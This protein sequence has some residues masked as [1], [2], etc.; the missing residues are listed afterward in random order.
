MTNRN[1]LKEAIA[2][3]KAVKETAIANAKA[4]LEEAFTPHL[5]SM[6]SK[7][8]EEMDRE[9]DDV[10]EAMKSKEKKDMMEEFEVNKF[11]E[12]IEEEFDLNEILAEL[13]GDEDMTEEVE[14]SEDEM[15]DEMDDAEVDLEDMSEADLKSFIEDVIADMVA[16]GELEA[17]EDFED[18]MGE[19]EMEMGDEEVEIT[20][21][22]ISEAIDPQTLEML[23]AALGPLVIGGGAF[24]LDK[25]MKALKSGKAGKVGQ[26]LANQLEKAGSAA[27][28]TLRRDGKSINES[29]ISEAIDPQTLEMLAAALGPLVIGGGAFALDKA[30]KA[31]KSGKA[32]KVGQALAN[33]LEKAG[34]A[35]GS[36]L[37]RDGKAINEMEE[38]NKLKKELQEVNLLNAKLL[39]TNKIFKSKNLSEDQKIKVLKSFDKAE[40]VKEA[41]IIFETLNEG[42]TTPSKSPMM[43]IKG[44]A[45]RPSGVIKESKQPVMEVDPQVARWQKIAGI[46]K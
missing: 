40:S 17:G 24:A 30:M 5:K 45:S 9:D 42:I 25:A 13:E 14:S 22:D 44:S 33:Q 10:E 8:L 15:E 21:S 27:G 34:S 39:Y 35:A 41:K 43:G 28:S 31:L 7:K 19:E 29:D 4:A 23:A 20:E 12:N 1:L 46:I 16:S 32:G 38:I 3:A 36:T 11:E 18:E 2:D 6:L 37:R 26:A